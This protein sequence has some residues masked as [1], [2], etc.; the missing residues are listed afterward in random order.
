MADS[1]EIVRTMYEAY[2]RGDMEEALSGIHPDGVIDFSVRG[3]AAVGRGPEALAAVTADWLETWDEYSEQLDE[4]RDLG[5]RV[6]MVV[7]Q[8]GRGKGSGVEVTNQW[9]WLIEVEDDLITSM[10]AYGSPAEALEAAAA[11]YPG[12]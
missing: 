9:A 8:T 2:R 7:T 12:T 3:D 11:D 4:I 1:V 5:G 10:I 6:M